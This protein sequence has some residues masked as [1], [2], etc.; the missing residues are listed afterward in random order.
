MAM[1]TTDNVLTI[2]PITLSDIPSLK[3]VIDATELFPSEMLDGMISGYFDGNTPE[4]WLTVGEDEPVAI[5]YCSPERMTYGTWNLLLI[6]VA[7]TRQGEGLGTALLRYIETLLTTQGE[8]L[9]LV[10]TS[11]LPEFERTREFYK[12]NS[13]D[14]EARICDYYAQGDDKVI[15]RKRLT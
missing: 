13:Y 5:A 10:E 3:T 12:K 6:A 8:R 9:L 2:R 14:E 15:F 11:G 1:K 4:L 7:P